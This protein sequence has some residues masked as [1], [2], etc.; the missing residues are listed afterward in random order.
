MCF[1]LAHDNRGLG[2]G[3]A[4]LD[5]D[6]QL[7]LGGRVTRCLKKRHNLQLHYYL[8]LFL[9]IAS[10]T[11]RDYQAVADEAWGRALGQQE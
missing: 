8:F 10:K 6:H 7:R 1:H 11:N 9:I 2:R 5:Q 3:R 4:E